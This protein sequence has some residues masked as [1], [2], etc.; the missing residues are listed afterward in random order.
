M[1]IDTTAPAPPAEF[2]VMSRARVLAGKGPVRVAKTARW[3]TANGTPVLVEVISSGASHSL[4]DCFTT[5]QHAR[6]HAGRIARQEIAAEQSRHAAKMIKLL[7]VQ[8][9]ARGQSA[10][11]TDDQFAAA[12]GPCGK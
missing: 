9:L 11:P 1:L 2:W 7:E 8:R 5:E 3:V 4:R 6:D 12:L 10:M